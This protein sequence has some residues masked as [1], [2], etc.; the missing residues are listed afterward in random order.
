M[1]RLKCLRNLVLL[2][3][4]GKQAYVHHS[5]CFLLAVSLWV[6]QFGLQGKPLELPGN[7]LVLCENVLVLS[8]K[9]KSF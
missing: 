2:V 3:L 5:S 1:S 8:L 4:C 7:Y 9:N 6:Q